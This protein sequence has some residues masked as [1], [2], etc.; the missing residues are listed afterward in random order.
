MVASV[1]WFKA[2]TWKRFDSRPNPVTR[3]LCSWA[4]YLTSGNHI[5]LLC[6]INN[7]CVTG[8]SKGWREI[9][10]SR[11]LWKWWRT[12]LRFITYILY[13]NLTEARIH[14]NSLQLSPSLPPALCWHHFGSDIFTLSVLKKQVSKK[15]IKWCLKMKRFGPEEKF[16]NRRFNGTLHT[17][18]SIQINQEMENFWRAHTILLTVVISRE[19]ARSWCL[20]RNFSF[21]FIPVSTTWIFKN[22]T[23]TFL[24]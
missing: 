2:K 4:S 14:S 17:H 16:T 1:V 12:T 8:S 23:Y 7:F 9:T 3:Q 13:V 6:K 19:W 15:S 24:S 20:E 5:F 21:S 11:W 10:Y 18:I 22:L